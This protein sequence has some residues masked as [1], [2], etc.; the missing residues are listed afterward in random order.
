MCVLLL[1]H[2]FSTL[3]LNSGDGSGGGDGG[4]LQQHIMG[5]KTNGDRTTTYTYKQKSA[6]E[7]KTF[8]GVNYWTDIATFSDVVV[9][10]RLLRLPL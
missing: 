7:I 6:S 3:L 10:W 5:Y 1:I 8:G 9:A 4:M 2:I